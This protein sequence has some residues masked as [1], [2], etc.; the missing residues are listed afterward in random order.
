MSHTHGKIEKLHAVWV[1][2]ADVGGTLMNV[3]NLLEEDT[4][5]KRGLLFCKEPRMEKRFDEAS[6]EFRDK[7]NKRFPEDLIEQETVI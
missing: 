5:L 1:M 6:K 4:E 2:P 3:L 7:Y